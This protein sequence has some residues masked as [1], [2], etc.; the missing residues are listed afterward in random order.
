MIDL[1]MKK[2]IEFING[3]VIGNYWANLT[4]GDNSY[5]FY[6]RTNLDFSKLEYNLIVMDIVYQR[7]K[8]EFA[9]FAWQVYDACIGEF[10]WT[11]RGATVYDNQI[12][13]LNC[14]KVKWYQS[15]YVYGKEITG[16]YGK[17]D[18]LIRKETNKELIERMRNGGWSI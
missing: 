12:E 5:N 11:Q 15:D 3:V 14:Y 8:L 6:V 13:I 18:E 7:L 4:R 2:K 10:K 1:D 17:G 16:Y 9:C